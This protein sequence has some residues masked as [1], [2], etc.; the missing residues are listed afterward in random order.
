MAAAFTYHSRYAAKCTL[1][2]QRPLLDTWAMRQRA[3]DLL[4][5][6]VR[7]SYCAS[8]QQCR[9]CLTLHSVCPQ[10][11]DGVRR[12]G[13]EAAAGGI[14]DE[15]QRLPEP[16]PDA[17]AAC[18]DDGPPHGREVVAQCQGDT[19]QT[20]CASSLISGIGLHPRQEMPKM[21]HLKYMV[22][23]LWQIRK[24]SAHC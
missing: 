5:Q 9:G 21:L 6:A 1:T 12:R 24:S 7:P 20:N 22:E 14:P 18:P 11:F 16:P 3:S 13:G 2:A 19:W 8:W 17:P 10:V 4:Q 15:R 23:H